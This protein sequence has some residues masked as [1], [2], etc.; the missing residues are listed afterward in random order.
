MKISRRFIHSAL[1]LAVAGCCS[2]SAFATVIG[3][4]NLDN[5]VSTATPDADGNYFSTIY[6]QPNTVLGAGSNGYIKS[7]EGESNPPG[8]T[9]ITDAEPNPDNLIPAPSGVDNCVIANGDASCNSEFQSGKRIKLDQTSSGAIDIVFNL[10]GSM[11]SADND[12]LYKFYQKYGNNTG[13][14]LA[15]FTIGLGFGIGDSFVSSV[16]GDGL[17]FV[18][19]GIDPKGSEFSSVFSQGLFG[20]DEQRG[21][22]QGYF[23]AERSG[24]NLEFVS[25]DLFRSAGIFGSYGDLFG[26]WLAYSMAPEGYFYDDDGDPTTDAILMAHRDEFT[27]EWIMN[28]RIDTDGNIETFAEGNDGQRLTSLVTDVEEALQIQVANI[29]S[30]TASNAPLAACVENSPTPVPC[31]AG[32]GEIEDLAKFNVTYFTDPQNINIGS[33]SALS[34]QDNQATFTLRITAQ[35]VSEPG[36]LG[37]FAAGF[38]LMSLRR[39]KKLALK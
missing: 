27:G 1:V 16:I 34:Y 18:D 9:V 12:G 36:V 32:V 31:L 13:S 30:P 19:F 6:D 23:S 26:D 14:A 29:T 21:R 35:D 5:V 7:T 17:S 10:D 33:D 3:S 28:R 38:G 20:T 39:V 11:P 37:L 25:E 24:F 4:V 2:G 8:I 15:G 22:P